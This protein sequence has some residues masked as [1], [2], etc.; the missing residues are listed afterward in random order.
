MVMIFPETFPPE[1]NDESSQAQFFWD[2][3]YFHQNDKFYIFSR[4]CIFDSTSGM[5][6]ISSFETPNGFVIWSKWV[7]GI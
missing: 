1:F 3:V 5:K 2:S 6:S 7:P 4:C